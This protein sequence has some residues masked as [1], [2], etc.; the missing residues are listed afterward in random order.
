VGENPAEIVGEVLNFRDDFKTI[1]DVFA[2]ALGYQKYLD[3]RAAPKPMPQPL[4]EAQLHDR[5]QVLRQQAESW[6][7]RRP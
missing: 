4:T 1:G 3:D 7:A 6:K 5:R 2:A